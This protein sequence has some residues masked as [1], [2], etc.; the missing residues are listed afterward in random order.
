VVAWSVDVWV[1]IMTTRVIVDFFK[2]Y[3]ERHRATDY[4]N[5]MQYAVP[6]PTNP[7]SNADAANSHEKPTT[8]PSNSSTIITELNDDIETSLLQQLDNDGDDEEGSDVGDSENSSSEVN[9]SLVVDSDGEWSSFLT[10]ADSLVSPLSE[11]GDPDLALDKS[12]IIQDLLQDT[13]LPFPFS[14]AQPRP[15]SPTLDILDMDL[16]QYHLLLKSLATNPITMQRQ[17]HTKMLFLLKIIWLKHCAT[18]FLYLPTRKYMQL[19]NPISVPE[20]GLNYLNYL[21]PVLNLKHPSLCQFCCHLSITLMLIPLLSCRAYYHK[22]KSGRK[23]PTVSV[24]L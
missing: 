22:R 15:S 9:G 5:A 3:D 12:K 11:L 6:S 19:L 23:Y 14:L 7:N 8:I 10:D 18:L 1:M 21:T 16:I 20:S 4:Y 24:E 17:Q 2:E 13:S